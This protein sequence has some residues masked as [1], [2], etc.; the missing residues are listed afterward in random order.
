MATPKNTTISSWGEVSQK[1]FYGDKEIVNA[2]KRVQPRDGA[3]TLEY[4]TREGVKKLFY[5]AEDVAILDT[6]GMRLKEQAA[7]DLFKRFMKHE[8]SAEEYAQAITD[9]NA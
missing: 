3:E 8:I 2:T 9:L 5:F 1:L 7:R 6:A 4:T